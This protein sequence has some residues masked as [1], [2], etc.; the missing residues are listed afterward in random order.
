MECALEIQRGM[1]LRNLDLSPAR[2]ILLRAGLDYRDVIAD[3]GDLSGHAVEVAGFLRDLALPGGLCIS[4]SVFL[5]V[6]KR[7]KV[8]FEGAGIHRIGDLPE[9]V[10][11]IRVL[12]A[13][14]D[15]P[16]RRWPWRRSA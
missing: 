16:R 7:I 3:K 5:E 1:A 2:R 12:L 10:R 14:D 8:G 4:D 11:A 6:R 13:Q 9:P 15:A